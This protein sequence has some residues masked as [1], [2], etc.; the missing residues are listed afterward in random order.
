MGGGGECGG[1]SG[2][3]GVAG[4]AGVGAADV[5]AGI[6]GVR[7][8][9]RGTS[10]YRVLCQQPMFF[11]INILKYLVSQLC[12]VQSSTEVRFSYVFQLFYKKLKSIIFPCERS[13]AGEYG[14]VRT[15]ELANQRKDDLRWVIRTYWATCDK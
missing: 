1:A 2:V 14:F 8:V 6:C 3:A 4:V 10:T 11:K 15:E 13:D 7:R 12:V 5:V 9:V